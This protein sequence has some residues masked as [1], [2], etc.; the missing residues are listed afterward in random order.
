MIAS[1]VLSSTIRRAAEE[2]GVTVETSPISST[3]RRH[4]VK[5]YPLV[6]DDMRTPSGRRKK[7]TAGDAKYQRE[8]VGFDPGRRVHAV[9]WHG[10][11]D[12]F[13]AC[14]RMEP[15]AKF[16]TAFDKWMSS[17]DFEAR[18]VRTASRNIGSRMYP[19][20]ACDACRCD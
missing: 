4:R 7:G 9:C 2:I 3:G 15:N 19:T 8:S 11:R 13:R 5:L 10:F 16:Y 1:N 12:F 20:M 17:E 18:H 14:Y 6:T